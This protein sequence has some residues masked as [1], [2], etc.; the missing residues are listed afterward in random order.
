MA[1]IIHKHYGK[2]PGGTAKVSTH[3]GFTHLKHEDWVHIG[4]TMIIVGLFIL[5][6]YWS[7]G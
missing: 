1:I 6:W 5:G 4:F 3:R 7:K 2:E